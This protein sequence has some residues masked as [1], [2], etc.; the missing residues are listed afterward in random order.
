MEVLELINYLYEILETASRVPMTS[1]IIIS[2]TEIEGILEE[3]ENKLPEEIKK[4][5]WICEDKSRILKEAHEQAEIIKKESIDMINKKAHNHEYIKIA[6]AKSEELLNNAQRNAKYLQ[7][8]SV[9]Y[10]SNILL[11]VKREINYQHNEMMEK[12]KKEMEN[13]IVEVEKATIKTTSTLDDNLEQLK[14][15]K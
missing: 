10:A 11:D 7:N 6:E 2:K 12:I 8:S 13:F 3:I 14:V 1:K 9:E 15:K 4:A 5:K